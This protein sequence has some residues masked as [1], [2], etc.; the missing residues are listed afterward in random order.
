MSD[1]FQEIPD[2]PYHKYIKTPGQLKMSDK[3][4]LKTLGNDINGLISY[5]EILVSGDSNAS[6][7]GRPLGNKYFLQ[8]P[9]KCNDIIT[10]QKVD[11]SIYINNVPAGNIPFITSGL[12][13]KMT[14]FK[15]IVPGTLSNL[16]ILNPKNIVQALSTGNNPDCQE[17]TMET[18]DIHN[19]KST[20]SNYVALIDIEKID[21][22]NFNSK[23]N[24]VTND[25]C[26]ESFANLNDLNDFQS[27]LIQNSAIN[28][29]DLSTQVYFASLGLLSVYILYCLMMK[30]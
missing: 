23:I 9:G 26:N 6:K 22:C 19:N 15:G 5:V 17:I 28:H 14:S 27:M 2:Y 12:G 10:N 13:V 18:I 25:K 11:R 4:T 30:K 1:I 24:P 16:E 20:E 7:T 3:G 21:P 29:E 8:T